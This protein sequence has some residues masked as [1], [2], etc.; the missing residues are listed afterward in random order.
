MENLTINYIQMKIMWNFN[1]LNIYHIE[2]NRVD[3]GYLW[4]WNEGVKG[5]NNNYPI[6]DLDY[7]VPGKSG[8]R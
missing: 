3:E 2:N 4:I 5:K 7:L 1:D 8:S 6:M